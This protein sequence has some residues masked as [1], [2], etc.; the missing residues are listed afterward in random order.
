MCRSFKAATHNA[1]TSLFYDFSDVVTCVRNKNL[2][3]VFSANFETYCLC[4]NYSLKAIHVAAWGNMCRS[5]STYDKQY[6]A[7]VAGGSLSSIPARN[8][9]CFWKRAW[10]FEK[11]KKKKEE[12]RKEKERKEERR[13]WLLVN[14]I[15]KHGAIL[16]FKI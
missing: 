12:K 7:L 5:F 14:S 2:R 4:L 16:I 9:T 3:R 13:N 6:L 1:F 10:V 11:K 15:C 8:G